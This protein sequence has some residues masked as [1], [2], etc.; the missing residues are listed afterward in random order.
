MTT[1]TATLAQMGGYG[2]NMD[3]WDNGTSWWMVA[4]MSLFAVAV[5]AA[6]IWGAIAISRSG[7]TNT[8]APPV[9][10]PTG[11][12]PRDILD[13]R[14]AHGEIDTADYEER[15]SKLQ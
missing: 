6:I 9:S 10:T 3:G 5:L 12:S 7:H 1:L 13:R 8:A 11:P 15:K 2:N 14:Y 4:M